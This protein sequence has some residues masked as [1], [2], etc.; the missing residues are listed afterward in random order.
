MSLTK[1]KKLVLVAKQV[2]RDLRRHS[3]PAE[4]LFWERVRNNKFLGL[5]F[6]RQHPLFVEVDGR[7]TFFIADFYCHQRKLAVELDGKIHDSQKQRDIARTRVINDLGVSVS[8]FRNSEVERN[9]EG[10]LSKL[11]KKL[12]QS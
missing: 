3:T 12:G 2:C 8:R 1:S 9:V 5:K 10:V 6:Y 7:Q 11:T 4:R